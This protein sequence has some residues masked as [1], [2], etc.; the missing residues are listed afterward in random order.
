MLEGLPAGAVNTKPNLRYV[1]FVEKV[2]NEN[3]NQKMKISH[4]IEHAQYNIL[5]F[6]SK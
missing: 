5:H 4:H 2:E 6:V 1:Q 3:E